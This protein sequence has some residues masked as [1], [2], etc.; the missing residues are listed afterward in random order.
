MLLS[1]FSLEIVTKENAG[2]GLDSIIILSII[3]NTG[4]STLHSIKDAR[5]KY[6][7]VKKRFI[8]WYNK[9]IN[10]QNK[11]VIAIRPDDPSFEG[12]ILNEVTIHSRNPSLIRI[13]RDNSTIHT[14]ASILL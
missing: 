13:S 8:R 9:L 1:D 3:V 2:W 7:K 10:K 5:L 14:E 4:L 11:S 6:R 12:T